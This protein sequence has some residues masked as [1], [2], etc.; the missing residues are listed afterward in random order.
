MTAA[1]AVDIGGTKV[2][3]ALVEN[4]E[5][6][7]H[8]VAETDA[9]AGP[10]IWLEKAAELAAPWGGEYACVGL[11]VTGMVDAAGQWSALNTGTLNIP[12][13]TRLTARA[14]SRFGVPA[15]ALNDA[16]AAAWGEYRFGAGAGEDMVFLTVSTGIGGGIVSGG[17]LL[18][19][20]SGLAG[21]FGQAAFGHVPKGRFEERS[22]GRWLASAAR[23]AGHDCDAKQLFA[24]AVKGEPWAVALR[25]DLVGR[26]ADLLADV[27]LMLDPVRIVLGGGIGLS[28]NFVADLAARH[29]EIRPELCPHLV[30]AQLGV[31]AGA[32]GVA[33]LVLEQFE[34]TRSN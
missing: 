29:T 22:A 27:Q 26:V 32:V 6:S 21:H 3:C 31:L 13:N 23:D 12:R 7:K 17:Q 30:Q 33:D 10:E 1:L 18:R 16:Q 25:N 4:G 11:A 24:A 9:G 34:M 20:R 14:Q 2:L 8:A 19:G 28:D 5:V 15:L